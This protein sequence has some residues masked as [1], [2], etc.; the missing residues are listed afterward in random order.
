[1][2]VNKTR[3]KIKEKLPRVRKQSEHHEVVK[4]MW[5]FGAKDVKSAAR[6]KQL[7]EKVPHAGVYLK[8]L[9]KAKLVEVSKKG[10]AHFLLDLAAK[11]KE[12]KFLHVYPE[13]KE[14]RIK[15]SMALIDHIQN[16]HELLIISLQVL[17]L[18]E[19]ANIVNILEKIKHNEDQDK[20]GANLTNYNNIVKKFKEK[21]ITLKG[22]DELQWKRG[23]HSW[24]L[25]K[26]FI[27]ECS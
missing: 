1:M 7:E 10:S 18:D 9:E 2:D 12:K 24:Y 16:E 8:N 20:D 25:N 14:A 26:D 5:K 6:T 23:S 4:W 13:I 3:D 21:K 22:Y 17:S 15:R 19:T 11:G 27:A